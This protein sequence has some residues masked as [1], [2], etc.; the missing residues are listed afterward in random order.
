MNFLFVPPTC[1]STAAHYNMESCQ[2]HHFFYTADG[3]S[4][5]SLFA[6]SAAGEAA[7]TAAAA[8]VAA[9][10]AAQ[11]AAF[12]LNAV[13]GNVNAVTSHIHPAA[14]IAVTH[15][16]GEG[17]QT[18]PARRRKI[19]LNDSLFK[20][21]RQEGWRSLKWDGNRA[22]SKSHRLNK[23]RPQHHIQPQQRWRVTHDNYQDGYAAAEA[24]G[25]RTK[26]KDWQ[27]RSIGS[28]GASG[29]NAS[30]AQQSS[31]KRNCEATAKVLELLEEAVNVSTQTLSDEAKTSQTEPF[32]Y[33]AVTFSLNACDSDDDE[34]D[35]FPSADPAQG[36][37]EEDTD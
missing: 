8:A 5:G 37:Q 34:A 31:G 13:T 20:T 19:R 17:H 16:F 9:V 24:S 32:H 14:A 21:P 18:F 7:A 3:G 22:R 6:A 1:G 4:G 36:R 10:T 27:P 29:G 28:A 30:H 2:N 35:F 11:E 33:E 12:A 26:A 25:R 23:Q 15:N